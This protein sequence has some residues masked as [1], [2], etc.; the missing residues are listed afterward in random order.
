LVIINSHLVF[1][2]SIASKGMHAFHIQPFGHCRAKQN[3]CR[4]Y[5][6]VTPESYC[7]R[8]PAIRQWPLSRKATWESPTSAQKHQKEYKT[9]TFEVYRKLRKFLFILEHYGLSIGYKV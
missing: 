4:N 9:R 7:Q 3:N 6:N 8:R 1:I 5:R 2:F